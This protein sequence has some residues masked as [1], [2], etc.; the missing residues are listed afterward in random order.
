MFTLKARFI[1]GLF[2]SFSLSYCTSDGQEDQ[3]LVTSP[4]QINNETIT[5]NESTSGESQTPD[6][7][8]ESN[9]SSTD[10]QTTET[11]SDGNS[12]SQDSD[13]NVVVVNSNNSVDISLEGDLV[14]GATF[15]ENIYFHPQYQQ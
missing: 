11:S 6:N 12:Q 5:N 8:S 14:R 13:S 3:I 15:E 4:T 2:L 1:F 9:S 10:S 7:S